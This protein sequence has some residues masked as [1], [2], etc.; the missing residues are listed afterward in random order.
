MPAAPLARGFKANQQGRSGAG[1]LELLL[2]LFFRPLLSDSELL[3]DQLLG[4]VEHL[5]LAKRQD[6]AALETVEIAIDL[7][8]V[9]Q[10]AGLDLLHETAIAAVPGLLVDVDILL[11]Q[12]V[13]HFLDL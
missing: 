1:F 6:L 4:V 9:E 10:R 13:E 3:H 2:D 11:A 8:D 12:D 7:G 5:A